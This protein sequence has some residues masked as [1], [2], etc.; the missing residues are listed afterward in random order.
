MKR[1]IILLLLFGNHAA[2]ATR[3]NEYHPISPSDAPVMREIELTGDPGASFSGWLLSIESDGLASSSPGEVDSATQVTGNFDGQGLLTVAVPD[4]EDPS[5][6]TILTASFTGSVG[7]DI[8]ANDDGAAD[9]LTILGAVLDALGVPD[10]AADESLL[11]G[12]DVGGQ[13]FA[14]T[15]DEPKLVFRDRL[16]GAWYAVND[17]DSVYDIGAVPIPSSEFDAFPEFPTIQGPNPTRVPEPSSIL[18][19]GLFGLLQSIRLT[20]ETAA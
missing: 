18:L 11:Y 6:T 20:R 13:D 3:I 15:G 8:D 7:D 14:Y 19:L 5:F 1:T 4:F 12:T 9:N 10:I 16:T 2:A 17:D